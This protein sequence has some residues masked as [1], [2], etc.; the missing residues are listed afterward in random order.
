MSATEFFSAYRDEGLILQEPV[1]NINVD[2]PSVF[3]SPLG[4]EV[5]DDGLLEY[6]T[7]DGAK[8]FLDAGTNTRTRVVL[9]REDQAELLE[10]LCNNTELLKLNVFAMYGVP[11]SDYKPWFDEATFKV[12]RVSYSPF[13]SEL[14]IANDVERAVEE[15][16][17]KSTIETEQKTYT[18]RTGTVKPI[19][20]EQVVIGD[21]DDADFSET[22]V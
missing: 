7:F 6:V 10:L 14:R 20:R 21:E 11:G 22:D 18:R 17:P 9:A 1:V 8:D 19:T 2:L 4:T 12:E 13:V 3:V 16:R 5:P 15:N